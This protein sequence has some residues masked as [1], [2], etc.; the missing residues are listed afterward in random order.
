MTAVGTST[1]RV[2]GLAKVSGVAQ[3]AA[4][5]EL[6]GMIYAKALALGG[7]NI[8]KLPLRPH[9]IVEAWSSAGHRA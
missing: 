9:W 5:I 3:Y 8:T 1:P 4:D 6:P 2:D 7:V